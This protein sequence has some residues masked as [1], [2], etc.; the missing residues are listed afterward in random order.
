MKRSYFEVYS[1]KQL[2]NDYR[3]LKLSQYACIMTVDIRMSLKNSGCVVMIYFPCA[4]FC[5]DNFTSRKCE[6]MIHC[7]RYL[8]KLLS[9]KTVL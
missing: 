2:L 3:R 4:N 8:R 7:V 1:S 5:S 9:K 6:A